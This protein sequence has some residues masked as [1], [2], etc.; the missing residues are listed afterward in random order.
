MQGGVALGAI[1]SIVEGYADAN[2][3]YQ[4][5]REQILGKVLYMQDDGRM[6]RHIKLMM[7]GYR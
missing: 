6:N 1:L 2:E 7:G 5:H 3:L 4:E